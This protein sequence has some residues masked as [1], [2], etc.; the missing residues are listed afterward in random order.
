MIYK[1]E[2]TKLVGRFKRLF[3]MEPLVQD[4]PIIQERPLR[5]EGLTDR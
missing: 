1:A 3:R 2:V 5:E 4:G